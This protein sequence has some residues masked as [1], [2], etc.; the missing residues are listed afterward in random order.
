MPFSATASA[1][2]VVRDAGTED[3]ENFTA[4]CR[5]PSLAPPV[6]GV[7]INPGAYTLAEHLSLAPFQPCKVVNGLS[8]CSAAAAP[9]DVLVLAVHLPGRSQPVEVD[10]GLGGNG[11]V[12]RTI[13]YSMEKA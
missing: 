2:G 5:G 1:E 8:V 7:L 11:Q 4:S 9:Y 13:L 12:A 10:I 6:E 3:P